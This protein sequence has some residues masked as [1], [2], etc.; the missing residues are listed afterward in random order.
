[1]PDIIIPQDTSRAS[2]YLINLRSKSLFN[3]YTLNWVEKNREE[4]LKKAPD[5]STFEKEYD[6]LNLLKDFEAYAEKEGVRRNEIK[7]EWVNQIVIDYLKNEITDSTAVQYD[8][9][10]DYAKSLTNKDKLV[11]EIVENAKKEDKK[12][13]KMNKESEKYIESTLKALIARNLY[14]IKYYYMCV[15]ENDN[16]LQK[17]I[18]ILKNGEYEKA[19]E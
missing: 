12:M 17:A 4:F 14:G 16:E 5:F 11:K 1:M 15:K 19:I 6:K 18:E 3:N 8:S 2:D 10:E 7:K 9:Y 13:E